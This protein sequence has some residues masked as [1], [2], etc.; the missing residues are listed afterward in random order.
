MTAV[1]NLPLVLRIALRMLIPQIRNPTTCMHRIR[2]QK[3]IL[4]RSIKM[5]QIRGINHIRAFDRICHF[6]YSEALQKIA[7][8]TNS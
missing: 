4:K 2:N 5:S 6:C 8:T 7:K 3:L 1:N